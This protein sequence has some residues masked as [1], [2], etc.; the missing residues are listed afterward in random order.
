MSNTYRGTGHR[1]TYVNATSSIIPSGTIVEMTDEIGIAVADIPALGEGEVDVS[2]VH[3]IAANNT[4][5]W[6]QGDTLYWD[7]SPGELVTSSSDNVP[8]GVADRAKLNPA[9]TAY[10]LL[11]GRPGPG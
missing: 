5:T 9:A 6:D 3:E 10:V 2:G 1:R 8:A 4:A 11:N 7:D